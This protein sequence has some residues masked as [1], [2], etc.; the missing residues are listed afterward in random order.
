MRRS[1]RV[2][3][4]LRTFLDLFI[5]KD[6]PENERR[7]QARNVVAALVAYILVAPLF[8]LEYYLQDNVLLAQ[9][10]C[11][12]VAVALASASLIR[13][14]GALTLAQWAA[15]GNVYLCF[16][17]TVWT[18]GGRID[19]S[20]AVWMA[21]F[22]LVSTFVFGVA[23]GMVSIGI[24][25]GTTVF[26]YLAGTYDW[27]AFPPF[28]PRDSYW[29]A[30]IANLGI[31]LVAGILAILFQFAKSISD[32]ALEESR[33]EALQLS[34]I[35]SQFLANMSHE[36][37][38]PMNAIIGLSGLALDHAAD[39]RTQDYLTKIN[40]AGDH[41][42][43]IINDILDFSKIESGKLEVESV[44]FDLE[45]VIDHLVSL[46][47]QRVEEKGLELLFNFDANLPK[48]L[49]G[50]PLRIGQILI[51]YANNALKFT[52]A[53]E[54]QLSV[55]LKESTAT[56]ALVVFSVTDT[57]IGLTQEQ[58]GRLFKS[59]EQADSSITRQYGGTGLGLAISK[60]LAQA[61][62]GDVGVSSVYGKGST[63]WFSARLG[64]ADAQKM[65]P[66]PAAELYGRRVLVVDDNASAATVLADM[67]Q[68]TGFPV[69]C[70][71]SGQAAIDALRASN[72]AGAP[73]TDA[74]PATPFDFVLMDWLMPG[75]DGL[76]AVAALQALALR[77]PP[78]VIMV[79]AHRRQELVQHAQSLGVHH[80]L[81]KPIGCSLLV[82]T[83]MQLLGHQALQPSPVLPRRGNAAAAHDLGPIQGARILLV[84]DNEINQQVACEILRG[85]G[86]DVDVADNGQI[87]VDKVQ[88]RRAEGQPYDIVLMDMQMP[89]M[90]GL[91]ATRAI[92]QT[93]AAQTLPIVAMTANAMQADRDLCTAAGMN[94]V[95]TKPIHQPQ[96]WKALRT[97]V[98]VR[99]GL[100]VVAAPAAQAAPA[101]ALAAPPASVPADTATAA[102]VQALRRVDGLDVDLGM[103]RTSGNPTFYVSML[104]RFVATQAD[105]MQGAQA[106]LDAGDPGT[107]ER[108]AHTLSSVAANIGA[109]PL[110]ALAGQA[111]QLLRLP[112]PTPGDAVASALSQAGAT[113]AALV[114]ALQ[115]SPGFTMA[116]GPAAPAVQSDDADGARVIALVAQ[117]KTLLE[118][119]DSAAIDLWHEHRGLLQRHYPAARQIEQ[120]LNDFDF[121]VASL[122][123]S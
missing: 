67:L 52:D 118:Q 102:L 42:L 105:A 51:N 97:W 95:V 23:G 76:Q 4:W 44:Q 8:I 57:G 56:Q 54:I 103:R 50:D 112:Q 5:P 3:L 69:H 31:T 17:L 15:A 6:W 30:V 117:L 60:S 9:I 55:T 28:A 71:H 94:D 70:V 64:I 74:A 81:S 13:V 82:N 68:A 40:H 43:G 2:F 14:F 73:S 24:A 41:L 16:L 85:Q 123:L 86:F 91:S 113:L 80:V 121:N 79:T 33:A 78:H 36:I 22:P 11:G 35:K 20:N 45:L 90:D 18:F 99:P 106:A 7:N 122:L 92:R 12:N 63:F 89:V 19:H 72:G 104:R 26:F 88:A 75:M 25:L 39:A 84:E 21:V 120:A 93:H 96:L 38:T 111:E 58:M 101:P 98:K 65:V 115:S 116:D 109:M 66:R 37:R 32:L 108:M 27:V 107:A 83:M 1:V 77:P 53:G 10:V 62:G 100:G 61:M 29:L 87:A 110:N 46:L 119:G 49:V 34:D 59:F 48:T 114:R 47:N